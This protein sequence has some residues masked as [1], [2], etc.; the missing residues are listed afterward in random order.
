M[1]I[2][3]LHCGY[4]ACGRGGGPWKPLSPHRLVRTGL[5]QPAAT[6]ASPTDIDIELNGRGG[7][8]EEATTNETK[9]ARPLRVVMI[10]D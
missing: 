9:H 10:S 8:D 6:S 4:G 1:L 5:A 2:K 3:Q 7:R